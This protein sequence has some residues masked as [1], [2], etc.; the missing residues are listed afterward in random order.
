MP[1]TSIRTEK[2]PSAYWES[3]ALLVEDLRS[4]FRYVSPDSKH[5]AVYSLKYYELILRACTEF[6]SLCKEKV[7]ELK[8]SSKKVHDFNIRDYYKLEDYFQHKP[9]VTEIIFVLEK[10]IR[11]QPLSDWGKGHSL[12]WYHDYNSVK[13]HRV[14]EFE[15]ANLKNALNSISALFIMIELCNLCPPSMLTVYREGNSAELVKGNDK[16]PMLIKR[17]K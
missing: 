8:L 9:S 10:S 17:P 1:F 5:L 4:S 15:R 11:F 7:S 12:S 14:S 13:H 2:P 3:L 6:E 16:W